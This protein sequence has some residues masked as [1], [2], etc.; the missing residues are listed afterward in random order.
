MESQGGGAI[1]LR[2]T[3]YLLFLRTCSLPTGWPQPLEVSLSTTGSAQKRVMYE[4]LHY[5]TLMIANFVQF[6]VAT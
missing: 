1:C 4:Q 6:R 2:L 3:R 5:T